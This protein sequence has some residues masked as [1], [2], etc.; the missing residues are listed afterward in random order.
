MNLIWS[1]QDGYLYG[2]TKNFKF[3][4]K[5]AMFDL[6]STLIKTKSGNKFANDAND[7]TWTFENVP[8]KLNQI[9]SKEYTIMIISNQGGI[10]IGKCNPD[11]WMNKINNIVRELNLDILAFCSTGNN[12]YRKP[13]PTFFHDFVPISTI[14]KLNFDLTFY[15]G[16]CAGRKGDKSDTDYKFALN[17]LINFKTPEDFF[18]EKKDILP[19]IKYPDILKNNVCDIGLLKYKN[20]DIIIMVGCQGSG[21]SFV[22]NELHKKFNYII[23][24]QDTLKIK[25][26][27]LLFAKKLVL[28]NK[29]IIIDSTNSSKESRKIWIDF[30]KENGYTA[31]VILMTT[32]LE[33]SK[34][35]NYF[36]YITTGSKLIPNVA[37]NIFKSYYEHP[38]TNEGL[39]EIVKLHCG[40][41]NHFAY[42]YYM[43]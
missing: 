7:W 36:R 38:E 42:Y 26:N 11:T 10:E 9:Y 32:N 20:K 21:K 30:A 14:N 37:Y 15:C 24:N 5:L 40:T 28:K 3:T 4:D 25:K 17:C 33:I 43:W 27:C 1:N 39:T 2:K 29:N 23:I 16:D 19:S 22:S 35:N 34:H 41:P 13:L 6:D 8:T 31:R 18:T 12:K